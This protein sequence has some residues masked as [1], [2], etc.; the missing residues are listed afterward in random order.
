[1]MNSACLS[2]SRFFRRRLLRVAPHAITATLALS[3]A[4]LAGCGGSGGGSDDGGA[5]APDAPVA[6][7]ISG[8][9]TMADGQPLRGEIK[10]IQISIQGVSEA[11]ERVSY[12]PAVKPDGTYRQ[13]VA[14]GQYSFGISRIVVQHPT[15]EYSLTLEPTGNLWNKDR[16]AAEGIVQDFVW[17]T[18]GPTPY[19]QSEGLRTS[20][21]T[22]W[23]G[24]SVDLRPEGYRNDIS[25]VPVKIPAGS[26]LLFTLTPTSKAIDGSDLAPV[27]VER[28]M[29]DDVL[30]DP[31]LNDIAPASYELSGTATLPD[32]TTKPMLLQGPGDYPKYKAAVTLPLLKD[33]LIGGYG[34]HQCT[35]LVE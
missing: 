30:F 11:A 27:T 5:A 4:F 3:T 35:F 34:K 24:M 22:H 14:G 19:G 10:D 20:N 26:K 31:D 1:M 28:T 7:V 12:S 33:A 2:V 17:K 18:T 15:G 9:I 29:S 16:D 6:N 8:R 25:A 23:Y 21:H 13:K 32:G